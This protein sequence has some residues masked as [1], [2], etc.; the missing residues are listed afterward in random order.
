[1]VVQE[2]ARRRAGGA[3]GRSHAGEPRRARRRAHPHSRRA[4]RR[5][6]GG[7]G[8]RGGPLDRGAIPIRSARDVPRPG[9]ALPAQ[10]GVETRAVIFDM[11]GVLLDSGAHHRQPW[12]VLLDELAITP[13]QPDFWRLTI[14]RPSVE[15]VPLLLDRAT[16]LPEARRLAERKQHHYR[17]LSREGLPP[18]PRVV[19]FVGGLVAQG[20]PPA[21]APSASP[22]PA[23]P[24]LEQNRLRR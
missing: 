22:A 23:E 11:D 9:A 18:V 6:P 14:G 4:V 21:G 17:L 16:P 10:V 5:R 7:A 13:Q 1:R 2:R 20:L 8:R 15:A 19:A 12:P 24:R 3:A